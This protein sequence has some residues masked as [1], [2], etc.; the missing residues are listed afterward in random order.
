M[1]NQINLRADELKLILSAA[2]SRPNHKQRRH[3]RYYPDHTKSNIQTHIL[4]LR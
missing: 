3:P 4:W 1:K 2:A